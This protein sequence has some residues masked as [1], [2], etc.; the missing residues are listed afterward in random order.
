M[1][2]QLIRIDSYTKLIPVKD[3]NVWE[4]FVASGNE[5]LE[6]YFVFD[7]E[8]SDYIISNEVDIDYLATTNFASYYGGGNGIAVCE[9]Q[10]QVVVAKDGTVWVTDHEFDRI[11]N[12]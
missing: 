12:A 2:A 1:Q 3:S 7:D 11:M 6:H 5:D 8:D 9:L 4:D 10:V